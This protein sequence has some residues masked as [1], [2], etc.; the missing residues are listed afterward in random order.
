[1][2]KLISALLVIAIAFGI[3]GSLSGCTSSDN[4]TPVN[5]SIVMGTHENFPKLS[6]N[7][8]TVYDAIYETCYTYG[9]FSAVSVEGTP[10]VHCS[11][12]IKEPEK[13]IDTA[14][15][16]QIAKQNTEAIIAECSRSVAVTPEVDTLGAVSISAKALNSAPETE[17]KKMLVYDS[18]LSTT[19]YLNNL[20]QNFFEADVETTVNKLKEKQAIP[21]FSRVDVTVV[22]IGQVCGEQAKLP[23]EYKAR[24]QE[25]WKAIFEAGNAKSIYFDPIPVKIVLNETELP[26]VS[27]VPMPAEELEGI[28]SGYYTFNEDT[29]KFTPDSCAFVNEAAAISALSAVAEELFSNP[30]VNITIAGTVASVGNGTGIPLSNS[31]A[32]AVKRI[33]VSEYGVDEGRITTVGLG[34]TECFLREDDL[35][36]DGSLN[37]EAAA[38][39]RAI[40]IYDSNSETAKNI[41][42]LLGI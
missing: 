14:K 35:N 10:T 34:K 39:N 8:E 11:Y 4:E 19:S 1:M 42:K 31:R 32:D 15:R 41:N 27:T 6:F 3:L 40:H 18:F 2:K 16:K 37:E 30:S 25:L 9:S 20:T 28:G 33:L 7:T 13:N 21:D 12:D 23:A 26:F 17:T 24:L 22:G 36:S 29:I 38:K 5:L